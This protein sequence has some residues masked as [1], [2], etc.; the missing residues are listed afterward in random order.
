MRASNHHA[1]SQVREE[2]LDKRDLPESRDRRDNK[3]K[4][5]P[6]DSVDPREFAS[7]MTTILVT[8]TPTQSSDIL[9]PP[10]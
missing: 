1:K 9:R 5:E 8:A 7:L 2:N 6:R 3:V 10:T 4:T